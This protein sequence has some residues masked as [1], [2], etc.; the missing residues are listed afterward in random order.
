MIPRSSLDLAV[1]LDSD[2]VPAT[3]S[4]ACA[5]VGAMLQTEKTRDAA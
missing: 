1:I 2:I 4:M 3:R 5:V